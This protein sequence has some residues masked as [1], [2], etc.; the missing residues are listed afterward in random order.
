MTRIIT[1][2]GLSKR[3]DDVRA[4]DGSMP[5]PHEAEPAQM[6]VEREKVRFVS[7]DTEC[8]AW[9]YPGTNGAC[10][11][12]AGG[13]RVTKEPGT[14]LFAKRF[15]DAGFAVLAFDYRRLGESGGQPR[16]VVRIGEQLADWQAAIAFAR[17]PAR[18]RPGP[19][20]DLGL[21]RRPAAT[22]SASRRATRSWPRRSRR[23]RTPTVRPPPATRRA[24]R[25][26]SRCCASPAGASSMPSA[27]SSAADRCWCRSPA[28]RGPSRSSPR[29]TRLDGDRAL[30]PGNRYPDWQQAV[31]ARSAL[32]LG[33]YRPGRAR[34]PRAVPAAR[35]R[36]RPGSVGA[37]RARRRARRGERPAPNSSG[38]PAGTTRRS[39][40]ATSRR[41]RPSCPSCAGTCST[42][43]SDPPAVRA[44]AARADRHEAD[45]AVRRDDRVRGHRRRRPD[46][47]AAA[48]A[49]DG[50]LAVGRP[51]R[52][53]GRRSPLRG[54]DAAA[55]RAP[56][57]D[58][59]RRRPV[60]ARDRSAGRGVPR[61]PRPARRHPGRQRHRR[62]A[63]PA[64]RRATAPRGWDGS[65]SSPATRSTTSRPG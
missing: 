22:S 40:T 62:R 49:A 61:P 12:M 46:G 65:C 64:A 28:S 11:I 25:S 35:A 60:A 16:Q 30:N 6:S 3:F 44:A 4:L 31:A 15:H 14:D 27:A 48:R 13:S 52:R 42:A 24:T 20:R 39:W 47:R 21:L 54:A 7:G 26:R 8:A 10:V 36:L 33:F 41:S 57:R 58:A 50:R 59:R 56:A 63:R 38:C 34:V 23:R 37:R 32:R 9:H 53:A 51:D 29:R 2:H 55:R 18:G 45:R 17:D 19:A 5:R 1:A 43:A